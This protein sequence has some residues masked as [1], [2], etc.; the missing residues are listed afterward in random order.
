M[1][2]C[3]IRLIFTRNLFMQITVKV[4]QAGKKHP[5]ITDKI[6]EI[7]DIGD[8]PKFEAFLDAVVKQ[9]VAEFT[10]KQNEKSLLPFLSKDE[11]S[12]QT[13]D[14]KVG[15]GRI[16][17]E[18]KVDLKD[19]QETARLA[20]EDGL[21]AVFADET[22]IESLDSMIDLSNSPVITFI[23]LTFLAGSYW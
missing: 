19:A 11:I 10:K 1:K 22:E 4:K 17:N 3:I 18:T 15:F 13:A 5:L 16:Y 12:N 20:F 21:F 7:E 2:Q 9:Q 14:G 8:K 23:R 6:I